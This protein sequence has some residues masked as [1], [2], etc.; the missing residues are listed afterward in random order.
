[1]ID[2]C[3]NGDCILLEAALNQ[4]FMNIQSIFNIA[5]GWPG[6]RLGWLEWLEWLVDILVTLATPVTQA[7][8]PQPPHSPFPA[9]PMTLIEC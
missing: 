2:Y 6:R 5:A 8:P 4:H 9:I 1:M 3:L 7:I